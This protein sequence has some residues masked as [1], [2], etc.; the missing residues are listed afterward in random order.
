MKRDQFGDAGV[1]G[2]IKLK[3]ILK[4]YGVKE[5]IGLTGFQCCVEGKQFICPSPWIFGEKKN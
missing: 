5:W 3:W 2:K 1:D 4:R